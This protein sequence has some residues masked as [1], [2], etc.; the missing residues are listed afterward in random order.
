VKKKKLRILALVHDHLVPPEDTTG[1]DV[2]EA[3]W[4]MEYDVIETLREMGHEV[5]VLGIHDDLGGIRPTAGHFKPHIVFNLLEAFADVTTFDQNVVSYLELL[6]LPYT[7][8]NPRG[9]ILARDKA[10][11]KK[12][13]A[14]HRIHVPEFAVVQPR[15]RVSLPKRLGFPAIVKSLFFEASAGISQASVVENQEQLERRA[16]F[17]HE[18]LGTAAIVEEYIDGREIYVGVMGNQRLEV[19]PPWEMSFDGHTDRW[20]IATE[21]V[22]WSAKYQKKHGIMTD[23]A[24]LSDADRD[25]LERIA[26]RTY[27][28]L[29]LNGYARVDLRMDAQ[30]RAYVIEANPNPNLAYG[31]D[32][33]ESAET[34]GVSYER[35][36]ERIIALGRRWEAARTG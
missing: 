11:S 23:R 5:R 26:Q 18:K 14:Y 22:K 25:K 17:I 30:G 6:R 16:A 4:K 1:I 19:L 21:R 31:E 10:L 36:L 8:C 12:L 35:L 32:F 33:A 13:L 9:L 29:D 3:E 27:R 2:L 15:R 34:A 28:A 20:K 24:E 7:G